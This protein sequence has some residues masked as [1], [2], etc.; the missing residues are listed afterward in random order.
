MCRSRGY[1]LQYILQS[2][3]FLG[4]DVGVSRDVLIPRSETEEWTMRAVVLLREYLARGRGGCAEGVLVVDACAGSGCVGLA[5]AQE[6]PRVDVLALE[7]SPGAI[8]V[9]ERNKKRNGLGDNWTISQCDVLDVRLTA[10][11]IRKHA[12]EKHLRPTLLVSNPPYIF[13]R[14][15]T[16]EGGLEARSV[17]KWE[18]ALALYGGDTFYEKLI[19][20]ADGIGVDGMV[21]EVGSSA[22][23]VR[24]KAVL[25]E[26]GWKG[27]LWEDM[28][29]VKRCVVGWRQGGWEDLAKGDEIN[30]SSL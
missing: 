21:F 27:G 26:G 9:A 16:H 22:Q 20:L 12:S 13:P 3:P 17:R 8:G 28:G 30:Y 14:E 29:G 6:V 24:V 19:Q 2:Q 25:E 23:A 18:P 1:P 11:T 10:E 4:L 5:I 15:L 7:L